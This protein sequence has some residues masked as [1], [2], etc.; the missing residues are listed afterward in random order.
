LISVMTIWERVKTSGLVRCL[1][2]KGVYITIMILFRN[3]VV[4][5]IVL[6]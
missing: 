5:V 3:G 6:F 2:I 1:Q 4:I